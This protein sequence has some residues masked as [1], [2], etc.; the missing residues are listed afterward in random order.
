MILN[1]SPIPGVSQALGVFEAPAFADII[2]SGIRLVLVVLRVLLPH[3]EPSFV[4]YLAVEFRQGFRL[5]KIKA[6]T[7]FHSF[8]RSSLCTSLPVTC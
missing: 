6:I 1:T 4:K 3:S 7:I 5:V 2:C 8:P